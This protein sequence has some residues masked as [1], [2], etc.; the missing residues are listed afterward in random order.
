MKGESQFAPPPGKTKFKKPSRISVKT[1]GLIKNISQKI[2]KQYAGKNPHRKRRVWR[3]NI[4]CFD[5][6]FHPLL[7]TTDFYKNEIY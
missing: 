1:V 4:F 7:F 5:K 6:F 3:V 2:E